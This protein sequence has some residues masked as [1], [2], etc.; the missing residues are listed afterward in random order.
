MPACCACNLQMRRAKADETKEVLR[1]CISRVNSI[2]VVHEFLSQQGS[3]AVDMA[4]VAQGIYKAIL[5]GMAAPEL[6]LKTEFSADN[7]EVPSEKATS[8]A[9]VLN[10]ML[11]NCFDHAFTGRTQ[12]AISV[13]LQK[14]QG[15]CRLTVTD[16]GVGL[17]PDFDGL[18]QNSLG[19]RIIKTMA[20]AD[21]HGTFKIENRPQ[22]GTCAEVALPLGG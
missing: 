22:G 8:I 18:P 11:Q 13:S 16:D 5:S 3:G 2:A 17:P 14:T 10:E 20:E 6:D 12:G 19:L 21:L 7:I 4:A 15:G 9:L 1:D